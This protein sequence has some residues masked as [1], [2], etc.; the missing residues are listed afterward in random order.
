M[1]RVNLG[2]SIALSEIAMVML[3]PFIFMREMTN[4]RRDGVLPIVWMGLL[5][6]LGAVFSDIYNNI[7]PLYAIKGIATPIVYLAAII[8]C[9]A[10]IKK[11]IGGVRWFIVGWTL[12]Y[13]MTTFVF[14]RS[15]SLGGNMSVEDAIAATVNYKLYWLEL[16]V[17]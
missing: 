3:A 5:W 11:N 16:F 10:L 14:Q 8:C 2:G 1:A 15:S 7:Y 12:S 6:L 4:M 17:M 13:I 9:Y